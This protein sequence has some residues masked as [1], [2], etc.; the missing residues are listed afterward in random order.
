MLF[1]E[2]EAE[3]QAERERLKSQW[4][5]EQEMIKST[6]VPLKMAFHLIHLYPL[7][8]AFL[9]FVFELQMSLFKLLTVTGME[10]VIDAQSRLV[11][12]FSFS[13]SLRLMLR[14]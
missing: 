7:L 9:P 8:I 4:F 14:F 5:R 1:S 2:R 6:Y 12:F 10:Q 3:E 11:K 13:L